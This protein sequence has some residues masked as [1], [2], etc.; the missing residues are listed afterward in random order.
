MQ[1][2]WTDDEILKRAKAYE[3]KHGEPWT[4]VEVQCSPGQLMRLTVAGKIKPVGM[5][6]RARLYLLTERAS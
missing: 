4:W 6:H 2:I 5:R 1:A 3:R